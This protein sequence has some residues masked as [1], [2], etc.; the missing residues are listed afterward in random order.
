[1]RPLLRV[2]VFST[3]DELADRPVRA[4]PGADLDSNRFTLM[5]ML[6]GCP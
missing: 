6:A 5:A 4:R 1:V 2:G 3:G